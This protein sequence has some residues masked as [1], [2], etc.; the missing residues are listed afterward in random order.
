MSKKERLESILRR[1]IGWV[2]N[3]LPNLLEEAK[4]VYQGFLIEPKWKLDAEE[5]ISEEVGNSL[6]PQGWA[7]LWKRAAKVRRRLHRKTVAQFAE[8]MAEA[9]AAERFAIASQ[10]S[11]IA[12][13]IVQAAKAAARIA[14]LEAEVGVLRSTLLF[15]ATGHERDGST[16]C[17]GCGGKNG[18]HQLNTEPE[19][20]G[21]PAEP[22]EVERALAYSSTHTVEAHRARMELLVGDL[23]AD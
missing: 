1:A 6:S 23:D 19:L 3:D 2:D 14:A 17:E 9:L 16:F 8:L 11:L 10:S 21:R 12:E 18:A 20:K 15:H 5:A 7:H 13:N 4:E 22:C